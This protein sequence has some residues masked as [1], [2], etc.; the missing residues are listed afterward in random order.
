MSSFSE[1]AYPESILRGLRAGDVVT[2][3]LT[4]YA[5]DD[6]KGKPFTVKLTNVRESG[7]FREDGAECLPII[8][9]EPRGDVDFMRGVGDEKWAS[10]FCNAGWVIDIVERAPYVVKY[11][12]IK[13][14]LALSPRAH[15][16]L[17]PYYQKGQLVAV[18]PHRLAQCLLAKD[19]TLDIV[20][21]L[22][23]T[24]LPEEWRKAGYP[25]LKGSYHFDRNTV[26]AVLWSEDAEGF[27]PLIHKG[28]FKAWLL[29]RLPQVVRTN[30]EFKA[31][32]R[33]MMLREREL[34][35]RDMDY[36]SSKD[37]MSRYNYSRDDDE[38]LDEEYAQAR[39]DIEYV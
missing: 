24:R 34:N 23:E 12:V 37:I 19:T 29:R 20:N 27:S 38:D 5:V 4:H 15:A 30:A 1:P 21:G 13:N 25:G 18:D 26:S 16:N 17:W 36:W 6:E 32:M 8:E 2:I 11:D 10:A 3:H 35:E 39:Y 7:E 9:W 33:E 28:I 22:S 31:D 14:S